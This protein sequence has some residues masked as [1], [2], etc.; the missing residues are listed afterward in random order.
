METIFFSISRISQIYRY[1]KKRGVLEGGRGGEDGDV[2][3]TGEWGSKRGGGSVVWGGVGREV[4][5]RGE[6]GWSGRGRVGVERYSSFH[7]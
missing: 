3:W 4:G 1:S 2:G 5:V 6:V 7:I